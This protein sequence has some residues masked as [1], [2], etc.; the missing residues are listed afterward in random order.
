[1][2]VKNLRFEAAKAT[3]YP[4]HSKITYINDVWDV[5]LKGAVNRIINLDKEL[6]RKIK[7]AKQKD[8]YKK[9]EGQRYFSE[10]YLLNK[11]EQ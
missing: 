7:Q 5:Q 10:Q 2:T 4:F 1:M 6:A 11:L 8:E 9:N 3:I